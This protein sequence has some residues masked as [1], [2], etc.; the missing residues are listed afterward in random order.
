M[1]NT[2]SISIWMMGILAATV[3]WL[4]LAGTVAQA[5]GKQETNASEAFA[6]LKTLAG[7]WEATSQRGKGTRS[8]EVISNGSPLGGPRKSPGEEENLAGQPLCGNPPGPPE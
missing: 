1:S 7:S 8:Y 5:A 6:K 3:V 4:G 2:R